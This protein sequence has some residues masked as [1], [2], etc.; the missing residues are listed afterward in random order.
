MQVIIN[1]TNVKITAALE[2]Y[3]QK[4]VGKLDRYMPNIS[5]IQVD[6]SRTNTKRGEDL[7]IAQITVRH[8]RGAILRAEEK[9]EGNGA[10]NMQAA[11]NAAVD[12]MY[13]R[14]DRFKGK[15]MKKRKGQERYFATPE[16]IAATQEVPE[17]KEVV[18]D[19]T[20]DY[21]D[22]VEITRHK[23]IALI[24]MTEQEAI[25]QMELLGHSFFMFRNA[26]DGVINV[27]YRRSGGG[28]GVLVP[29]DG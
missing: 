26:E 1:G 11:I 18:E 2:D 9:V 27:L 14:I 10:D 6:L 4:K 29:T 15:R 7:S 23:V 24:P 12:K 25:A 20:T 16:E 19:Y 3:T 21:D 5:E 13:R 8:S 28:Y 17:F 22:D